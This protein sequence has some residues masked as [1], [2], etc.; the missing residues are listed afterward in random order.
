VTGQPSSKGDSFHFDVSSLAADGKVAVAILPASATDRVVFDKPGADSL[1]VTLPAA[2]TPAPAPSPDAGSAVLDTGSTGAAPSPTVDTSAG[3]PADLSQS[4]L[5]ASAA[6]APATAAVP[7][8]A[9]P[10]AAA[11][12]TPAVAAAPA[13]GGSGGGNKTSPALIALAVGGF[14]LAAALWAFAGSSAERSLP[15]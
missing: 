9:A 5:P 14:L 6:P 13:P 1:A 15:T 3:L 7:Q 10:A 12:A 4:S 8:V 11:P 2:S